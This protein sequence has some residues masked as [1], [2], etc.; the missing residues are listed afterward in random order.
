MAHYLRPCPSPAMD[1]VYHGCK[2]GR[3]QQLSRNSILRVG[4]RNMQLIRAGRRAGCGA[5]THGL[6]AQE[7]AGAEGLDAMTR[8]LAKEAAQVLQ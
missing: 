6:H 8:E 7:L 1:C 3:Q 5:A 2:I 4:M